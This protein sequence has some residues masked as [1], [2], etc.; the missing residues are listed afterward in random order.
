MDLEAEVADLR[1]QLRQMDLT[2]TR[3]VSVLQEQVTQMRLEFARHEKSHEMEALQRTQGRRWIVTVAI[4]ACA[5]VG[6][7]YPL[8]LSLH[9]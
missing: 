7:L 4:A 6:G 3:G 9:H 2:G 5:A 1:S 8:V